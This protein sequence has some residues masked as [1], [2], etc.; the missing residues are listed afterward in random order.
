MESY[1][2]R[3]VRFAAVNRLP[4]LF[5]TIAI[6]IFF[7]FSCKAYKTISDTDSAIDN[8]LNY[9]AAAQ[10]MW[11]GFPTERCLD[12]A[13][14]R[15]ITD[16]TLFVPVLIGLCLHENN[17]EKAKA[18]NK[19][20]SAMLADQQGKNGAWEF[21]FR[22]P[23]SSSRYYFPDL[24]DTTLIAWYLIITGEPFNVDAMR[25]AV[26]NNK[27]DGRYLTFLRD[28]QAPMPQTWNTDPVVNA[29]VMMLNGVMEDDICAFV[30]DSVA[31]KPLPSIYYRDR[32]VLFYMLSRP[33]ANGVSCLK[34]SV[35]LLFREALAAQ[36][37]NRSFGSPLRTAAFISA[38]VNIGFG[39]NVAVKKAVS[40]LLNTQSKHG[41]WP[42]S[43]FF[44]GG[45]PNFFYGSSELTTAIVIEALEKS[46]SFSAK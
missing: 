6:L 45:D 25:N 9:I 5:F 38:S 18:I 20:L 15:C 33:Y 29:Q 28:Y 8:A 34:E 39:E 23:G 26:L 16:K 4:R 10:T 31:H 7:L 21:Y 22:E 30:N 46:R 12:D 3:T 13:M 32:V 17:N 11:G 2:N 41:S 27:K 36:D 42:A 44:H 37:T 24:D 43:F 14:G 35:D 19:R 40:W 1:M